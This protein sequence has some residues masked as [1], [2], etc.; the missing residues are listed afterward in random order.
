MILN[1]SVTSFKYSTKFVSL[2]K[3][4]L[5]I[6]LFIFLSL[7]IAL[8]LITFLVS[9]SNGAVYSDSNEVNKSDLPI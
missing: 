1:R 8:L 3:M 7:I 4:A 9:S 2:E 5:F 6:S